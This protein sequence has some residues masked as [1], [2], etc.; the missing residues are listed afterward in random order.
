MKDDDPEFI[1]YLSEREVWAEEQ[2]AIVKEDKDGVLYKKGKKGFGDAKVGK[3]K[4][5]EGAYKAWMRVAFD[6]AK[7]TQ[8]ALRDSDLDTTNEHRVVQS[9]PELDD[10]IRISDAY[11]RKTI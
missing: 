8:A 4:D 3:V 2:L 10:V 11:G 1:K 5:P 6:G 9:T 7:T